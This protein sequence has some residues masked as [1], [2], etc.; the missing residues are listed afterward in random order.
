MKPEELD[1][2][3]RLHQQATPGQWRAGAL[4]VYADE[5]ENRLGIE[6]DCR[7]NGNKEDTKKNAR[8]IA[9]LHNAFPALLA[10]ARDGVRYRWLRDLQ[11]NSLHL[12][13]NAD[14]AC[15]YMTAKEWI[16]SY[17]NVDEFADDDAEE[18]QRMKDT[19]TIWALQVYS[20]TPV[21]FWILHSATLD[22]AID[23]AMKERT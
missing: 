19:N 1:E 9:S 5:T 23:A 2:L 21:N 10:L 8:A 22:A 20:N 13:R 18:I 15:N 11:C 4:R 7:G 12:T 6:I 14:H 17:A 16:E 3:E